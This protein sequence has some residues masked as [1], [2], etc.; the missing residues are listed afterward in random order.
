MDCGS[1]PDGAVLRFL[2]DLLYQGVAGEEIWSTRLELQASQGEEGRR[3][4]KGA[5]SGLTPLQRNRAAPQGSRRPCRT[6]GRR[7]AQKISSLPATR[8]GQ[9]Y[10]QQPPLESTCGAQAWQSSPLNAR[11]QHSPQTGKGKRSC[12]AESATECQCTIKHSSILHK[13]S[14]SIEQKSI[15]PKHRLIHA[16]PFPLPLRH[17][18]Q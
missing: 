18:I 14:S 16:R 9:F 13:H 1:H 17:Q 7:R 6:R 8:S 11:T 10:C 3:S 15:Q 5:V 4:W 12:S 2:L